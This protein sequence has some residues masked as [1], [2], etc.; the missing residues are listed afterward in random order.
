[1][2]SHGDS[3]RNKEE[4]TGI[5]AIKKCVSFPGLA[6]CNQGHSTGLLRLDELDRAEA[7]KKK[8]EHSITCIKKYCKG[9]KIKQINKTTII[10]SK[11]ISLLLLVQRKMSASLDFDSIHYLKLL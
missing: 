11:A 8:F 10:Y 2:V 1:M 5:E 9:I 4:S 7:K 6:K 3:I